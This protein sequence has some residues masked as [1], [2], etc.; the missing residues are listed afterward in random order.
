MTPLEGHTLELVRVAVTFALVLMGAANFACGQIEPAQAAGVPLP[1]TAD[2]KPDFSGIWQAFTTASWDLEDHGA[3]E[4]VPAGLG[5]V[6]GGEIPYQPWALAKKQQHAA[7]RRT[8]DPLSQCYMPGVPRV[9]YLPFPFEI[10]QTPQYIGISYEYGHTTRTVF[11]DGSKK[12]EALEFWMG[13]SHGHWEGDTLVVDVTLFTDKTWFDKV[14]NFHSLDLHVV[15]RYTYLTE[16]HLNYEATIEDPQVFTR[17]WKI[18]FPLY[19]RIEQNIELLEYECLEFM[20]PS[21]TLEQYRRL[22]K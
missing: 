21:P 13:D 1:R 16:N 4:G 14:G 22:S 6:E 2:G 12:P 17:P 18:S 9:T 7:N 8:L 20:E 15:E 19:R 3:E 10:V 5:V 11:L